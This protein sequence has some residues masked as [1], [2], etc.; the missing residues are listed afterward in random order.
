MKWTMIFLMA[1]SGAKSVED[2]AE[3]AEASTEPSSEA[4]TEPASEA[5][6]ED[7]QAEA[8]SYMVYV[9]EVLAKTDIDPAADWI[10]LYNAEAE[11]VD[12]S[13]FGLQDSAGEVWALPAGT[14]IEAGGF[15]QIWA[16]D[17][18]QEGLHAPFKLSKDGEEVVLTD[19]AGDV[20]DSVTFPALAAE[21]TYARIID[22]GDEWEVRAEGTPGA[23]NN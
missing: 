8:S 21:E 23:S 3:T 11:A 16:D 20:V 1:C 13:G 17:A 18:A 22:G 7:T 6:G 12:L 9:N 15:L 14:S 4:S 19:V 5:S 10:E 2:K